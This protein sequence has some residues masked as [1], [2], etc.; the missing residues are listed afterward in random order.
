M[1]FSAR[2]G[3]GSRPPSAAGARTIPRRYSVVL[4][5]EEIQIWTDVDGMMTPILTDPLGAAYP[6]MDVSRGGR[7]RLLRGQGSYTRSTI[8]PAFR[9][10]FPVRI[11][12]LPA[13]HV[14]GT[15]ILGSPKLPH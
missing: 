9:R 7:A 5:A 4:D 14:K 6:E 2:P 13:P 12:K 8:I 15:V 3:R 1:D 11:L 10:T